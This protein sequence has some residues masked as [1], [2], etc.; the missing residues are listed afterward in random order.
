MALP[1]NNVDIKQRIYQDFSGVDFSNEEVKT[2]RSPD[3]V[4]MWKN[5]NNALG[6]GIETRPGMTLLGS[7]GLRIYGL[8]SIQYIF[9]TRIN[10]ITTFFI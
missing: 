3:A 10:G 9:Q 4:N 8:Y 7:F 1:V 2:Y 5:Y 6:K